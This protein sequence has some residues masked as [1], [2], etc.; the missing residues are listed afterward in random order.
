[1]LFH[2][3]P[4]II[5]G[6]LLAL[7]ISRTFLVPP[8]PGSNVLSVLQF[9]AK[10]HET[11]IIISLSTVLFHHVRYRLT[12]GAA[13]GLPLGLLTS[14]FQLNSFS[15]LGS[16]E[17][18][19]I[20]RGLTKSDAVSLLLI[21][22]TFILA[23]VTGPSSAITMLPKLDWWPVPSDE[24]NIWSKLNNLE[25][26]DYYIGSPPENLYPTTVDT[27]FNFTKQCSF[28]AAHID[29]CPWSAMNGI[30]YDFQRVLFRDL[31]KDYNYTVSKDL[32]D[33]TIRTKYSD[34]VDLGVPVTPGSDTYL[35]VG[36][37]EAW[38][39]ATTLLDPVAFR[40]FHLIADLPFGKPMPFSWPVKFKPQALGRTGLSSWKQPIVQTQCAGG[41]TEA[42]VPW[43]DN[44]NCTFFNFHPSADT[45]S[46][47]TAVRLKRSS[48]PQNISIDGFGFVG[49]G[50]LEVQP[51]LDLSSAFVL[52]SGQDISMPCLISAS[53]VDSDSS[54][55]TPDS[56]GLPTFAIDEPEL[57]MRQA[58]G[59]L[60]AMDPN[61]LQ[62]LNLHLR[63][64][65]PF[66][67]FSFFG[68]LSTQYCGNNT[69]GSQE[70]CWALGLSMG[71]AEGLSNIP[72]IFHDFL[73]NKTFPDA[74]CLQSLNAGNDT[75]LPIAKGAPILNNYTRLGFEVTQLV[76]AYGFRDATVYLAFAV[77]I[78]HIVTVAA[79]MA[80]VLCGRGSDRQ[81]WMSLGELVALALRSPP[82]TLLSHLSGTRVDMSRTW[83]LRVLLEETEESSVGLVVRDVSVGSKATLQRRAGATQPR[84]A[85]E[86]LAYSQS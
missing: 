26:L 76:Y 37:Y 25:T 83:R 1:M 67:T 63:F 77:L 58:R 86:E 15:F 38:A 46:P 17:L 8:W 43:F 39:F 35:P 18:F 34:V 22:Y 62:N 85:E 27:K 72:H 75:C 49:P 13:G 71:I 32:F 78:L 48:L 31:T 51:P 41:C 79:H 24:L 56:N 16:H 65:V 44:E 54:I 55:T 84:W 33:K 7:Y 14:P 12:N 69:D 20:L 28:G 29:A 82:S 59:Q 21:A 11:L 57:A 23:A 40:A 30:I 5:T 81:G 2:S 66:S 70:H 3:L 74:P 53:W 19:A 36:S 64:E 68:N 50:A 10:V 6:F 9:A 47:V 80:F 45:K 52:Q 61:W 73:V 4:I 42:S 60:I